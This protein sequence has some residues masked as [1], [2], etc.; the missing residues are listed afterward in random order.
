M[1]VSEQKSHLAGEV[2]GT[3]MPLI[4]QSGGFE[5]LM[6]E[7]HEVGERNELVSPD[8]PPKCP[9]ASS[10]GKVQALKP[11]GEALI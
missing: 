9:G 5:G 1:K 3:R 11:L 4:C 8:G 10:Q 6:V 2:L 7:R